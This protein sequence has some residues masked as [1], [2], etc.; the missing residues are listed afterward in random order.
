MGNCFGS[1]N[2]QG[3]KRLSPRPYET[4]SMSTSSDISCPVCFDELRSDT[5]IVLSECKH[6]LCLD[7]ALKYYLQHQGQ[8][9]PYCRQVSNTLLVTTTLIQENNN[10]LSPFTRVIYHEINSHEWRMPVSTQL[11]SDD[12]KGRILKAAVQVEPAVQVVEQYED[13]WPPLIDETY[14]SIL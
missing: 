14:R 13:M 1:S 11:D 8:S 4:S 2:S 5:M 3:G 10:N 6:I 7:C 9:C 12:I